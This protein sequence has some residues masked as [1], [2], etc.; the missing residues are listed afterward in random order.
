MLF[1]VLKSRKKAL[2]VNVRQFF[3]DRIDRFLGFADFRRFSTFVLFFRFISIFVTLIRCEFSLLISI[4]ILFY[5]GRAKFGEK[6]SYFEFCDFCSI[7]CNFSN[8]P[9]RTAPS[10]WTDQTDRPRG[11]AYVDG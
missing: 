11:G 7:F 1:S 10:M 4:N 6:R 5:R 2:S 8:F 9:Q 3:E